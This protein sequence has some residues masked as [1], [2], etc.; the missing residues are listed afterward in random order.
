MQKSTFMR[1]FLTW[2]LV[3][4]LAA[5]VLLC[6]SLGVRVVAATGHTPNTPATDAR[7]AMIVARRASGPHPSPG[8]FSA[9]QSGTSTARDQAA[10]FDSRSEHARAAAL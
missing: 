2:F 8:S 10:P 1:W 7:L 5:V 3:C 9:A 4:F 6:L